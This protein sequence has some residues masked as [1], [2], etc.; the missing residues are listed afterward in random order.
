[1]RDSKT[2]CIRITTQ[3][4]DII[5]NLLGDRTRRY[6]WSIGAYYGMCNGRSEGSGRITAYWNKEDE[7]SFEEFQY[8]ILNKESVQQEYLIFN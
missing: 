7:I 8:H 4:K 5:R 1:M 6:D 2:W 3:N